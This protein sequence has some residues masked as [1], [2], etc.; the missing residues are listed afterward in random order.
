MANIFDLKNGIRVVVDEMPGYKSCTVGI[1]I[2]T[3]SVDENENSSGISHFIEHMCF[4]GTKKRTALQIAN[5]MDSIGGQL[6]AFTS[7][8][9]TCYHARVMSER[10]ENAIDIL[11]DLVINSLFDEKEMDKEKGVVIEEIYMTNDNPED[12][13]HETISKTFF[14][15]SP[16]AKPILGTEENIRS[17]TRQDL[18]EHTDSYYTPK[19]MVVSVAGGISTTE[20]EKLLNKYLGDYK[21]A[22]DE[23]IVKREEYKH[24]IKKQF[25]TIGKDTEQTQICLAMRGFAF[26]SE[27]RYALSVVNNA[28]GG[29]MS[30]R[31][32]QKIREE[33]GLA[34]SVYSYPSSYTY[35]GMFTVYSGTGADN[36]AVV[37]E[38][39]LSELNKLKQEGITE[40]EFSR[41]M[42]QL[43]GG[44]I[45]SM[46]STQAKMNQNGKNLLLRGKYVSVD[47]E[48]EMF[49]Q[50]KLND[51]ISICGSI[52]DT[53]NLS[54][55]Y[56][57][58]IKDENALKSMF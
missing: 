32:F 19:R 42:E 51:C 26:L 46:E 38:L 37:T 28:F 35:S 53:D 41:C 52:I 11:S 5:E 22:N 6:N 55:V 47:E 18:I 4:K 43:K 17:F 27:E 49:M 50:T 54:A 34:Y 7:K 3:G 39:I 30:S 57:G 36:A 15:G 14:G 9:C 8:E 33:R 24:E 1:W 56:V 25:V 12:L 58:K 23:P 10:I 40:K 13:A 2:R 16:L 21:T 20:T 44:Y 48:I 45:L 31:L 29:T